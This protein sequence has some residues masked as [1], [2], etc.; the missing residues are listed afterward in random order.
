MYKK[1]SHLTFTL[2]HKMVVYDPLLQAQVFAAE[3][4]LS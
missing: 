2:L 4:A 1:S 3:G